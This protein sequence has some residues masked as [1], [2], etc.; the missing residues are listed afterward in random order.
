M[1]GIDHNAYVRHLFLR[2]APPWALPFIGMLWIFHRRSLAN[3]FRLIDQV[4]EVT[5]YREFLGA[6]ETFTYR[7]RESGYLREVLRIR[8]SANSL[9]HFG[10]R[11][12]QPS[13]QSIRRK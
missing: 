4:A 13:A 8:L 10:A 11:L 12:M 3:D 7:N 9:M 5:T 1:Q 6:V 2:C